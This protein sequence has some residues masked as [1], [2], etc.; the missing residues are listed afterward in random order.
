MDDKK[1]KDDCISQAEDEKNEPIFLDTEDDYG[2]V[3][4]EWFSD[5]L[6]EKFND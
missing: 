4:R 2:P 1:I 3:P 6:V 5:P